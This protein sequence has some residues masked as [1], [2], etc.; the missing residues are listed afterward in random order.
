MSLG[1]LRT[2]VVFASLS[3]VVPSASAQDSSAETTVSS[4][5]A[6]GYVV[7]GVFPSSA[8]PGILLQKETTIIICLFEYTRDST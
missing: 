4:L 6:E 1:L 7:K 5:L 3:A 8:G 2:L